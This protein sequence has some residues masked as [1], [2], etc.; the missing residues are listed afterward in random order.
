MISLN[1]DQIKKL[2]DI[3][4]F[5]DASSCLSRASDIVINNTDIGFSLDITGITHAE[6]ELI[7]QK[8]IKELKNIN[9]IGNINIVLTSSAPIKQGAKLGTKPGKSPS[10]EKPKLHIDGVD[11]VIMVASGKGGVGK[12][13]ISALL[14]SKLAADGMRV[15]I[16]DA[17]IYGP[18]MPNIFNLSG[19]P[20]LDGNKMIPLKNHGISI[21]SIGFLTAPSASISWRGPMASKALYQLLSL[22]KW[23]QLDYL[24]IDTPPGTGDIHLSLLQNYIIDKVFMITTPQKISEIDVS[25]AISLYQKFNIPISGIIENMSYY[26][27][28][29]SGKKIKLF[30]GSAGE[31]ISKKHNIP[32]LAQLPISPGLSTACDKGESLQPYAWLLDGVV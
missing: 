10:R 31:E 6:A 17:D 18:S 22:T 25:R 5:S 14:G 26:H 3:I 7:R 2:L 29:I 20:E 23:G 11:Q 4:A 30:S 1:K 12:S 15:G 21:N 9:N 24:I 27:E 32:M 13:T 19:K 28:P 16:I 8:A